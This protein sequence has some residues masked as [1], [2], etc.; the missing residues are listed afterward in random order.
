[1]GEL[2]DGSR[3]ICPREWP[4]WSNSSH[5]VKVPENPYIFSVSAKNFLDKQLKNN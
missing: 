4:I 3:F 1:V 5:H 2:E